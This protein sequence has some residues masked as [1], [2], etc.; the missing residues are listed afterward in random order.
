MHERGVCT[1]DGCGRSSRY[2]GWC[3]THYGRWWRHG[4]PLA[5]KRNSSTD[6]TGLR[7]G[8]LVVRR[9]TSAPNPTDRCTYWLCACD[10]GV[11]TV[12]RSQQLSG[13]KRTRSCGC[14]TVEASKARAT[15]GGTRGR[16][17]SP[18]YSTWTGMKARCLNPNS[19]NFKHYGDRGITVCERWLESF[20]IFLADM[21]PRPT[22]QHSI[23]RVDVNGNYEPSNC[24]WATRREQRRNQRPRDEVEPA[25]DDDT[26]PPP[27]KQ[28]RGI[29]KTRRRP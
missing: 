11:Q 17:W 3:K 26:P 10:C 18:E 4:D 19:V 25:L 21:G 24:R 16:K 15:H 29:A 28:R 22:P 12:V 14:L 2:R 20:E 7:I 6:L 13:R 1:I 9:R 27:P 5:L 23:D 8:R